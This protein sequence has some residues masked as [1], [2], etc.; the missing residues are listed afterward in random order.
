[1][2]V[3]SP[4]I[5]D[6]SGN[7]L[8][9]IDLVDVSLDLQLQPLS[10]AEIELKP[11]DTIP[12]RSWIAVYTEH[13]LAGIFRSRPQRDRYGERSSRVSLVHGAC[14]LND[15][16]TTKGGDQEQDP[17]NIAIAYIMQ[18][19]L[20]THWRLGT[21]SATSSVVYQLNGS[22]VLD[23][24][25][26]IMEQLPGYM[27]V[28]DQ[29]VTPWTLNVLPR[30][31]AVSAEG[32][33][34]R[35][36]SSVEISRDDTSLCNRVYYGEND[37]FVEDAAAIQRH[38]GVIEYR[39]NESGLT[40]VQ[41]AT[42]AQAYL[43]NH[44]ESKLSV[45]ISAIDFYNATGEP[46]D[47][48]ALGSKYRLAIPDAET[49]ENRV[50]EAIIC[51]IHY[52]SVFSN[53]PQITLASDPDTIITFLKKQRRSGGSARQ[54]A[55]EEADKQ[56]Q[57]WV[58]ENDVYK[59]SVYKIMGVMYDENGNVIYQTD[60]V[61]G[62]VIVDDA[63]N[64]VPVYNTE[65][66]GS[67]AGQVTESATSLETLYTKTGVRTLPSGET[68]IVSYTSKV[69]QT[70]DSIKSEVEA[71]RDGQ[72]SLKSRIDQEADKIGLFVELKNGQYVIKRAGIIAAINEDGT[73]TTTISADKIDLEGYVTADQ[74]FATDTTIGQYLTA[75]NAIFQTKVKTAALE[76]TNGATIESG[77]EVSD[78]STLTGGVTVDSLTVGY[79]ASSGYNVTKAVLGGMVKDITLN[80]TTN[81]LTITKFNGDI[82]NF[83]KAASPGNLT[84]SWS[85]A[86]YTVTNGSQNWTIDFDPTAASDA[87]WATEIG[88]GTVS[89]T[90]SKWLDFPLYIGSYNQGGQMAHNV[91]ISKS[92]NATAV[93]T[94]GQDSVVS[95]FDTPSSVPSTVTP[96][97][98]LK[99][100]VRRYHVT[101]DGTDVVDSY[102]R[103]PNYSATL[104]SAS[105]S[106]TKTTLSDGVY[107]LYVTKDGAAEQTPIAYYEVSGSG[108]GGG[109]RTARQ[110]LT[111][112]GEDTITLA[113][114]DTETSSHNL[115]A[116]YTS[117]T[118][119]TTLP[120]KIDAKEVYDAGVTAGLGGVVNVVKQPWVGN[121]CEFRPSAGNGSSA[122]VT[123]TAEATK[124]APAS[125]TETGEI[126]LKDGDNQITTK[127]LYLRPRTLDGQSYVVLTDSSSIVSMGNI[128][129]KYSASGGGSESSVYAIVQNGSITYSSDYQT[130]FVPVAAKDEN[131]TTLLSS[132]IAAD[133]TDAWEN[134]YTEGLTAGSG[135]EVQDTKDI[136]SNPITSNNSDI[137]IDPDGSA[138]AMGHVRLAVNVPQE[139]TDAAL[140]R[141]ND[142]VSTYNTW[143][144]Y[145]IDQ[146][147]TKYAQLRIAQANGTNAYVKI[148]ASE[149]YERGVAAG[150]DT[151]G[152]RLTTVELAGTPNYFRSINVPTGTT[153]VN[154]VTGSGALYQVDSSGSLYVTA[155]TI[156]RK[157][158]GYL[159]EWNDSTNQYEKV[160]DTGLG[161]WFYVSGNVTELLTKS[162]LKVS[163]A[164]TTQYTV[165]TGSRQAYVTDSSGTIVLYTKG[166]TVSDTYYIKTS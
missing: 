155:N 90:N 130:A 31:E 36:I 80:S 59:R 85:G 122:S 4:I 43:D 113:A 11:G 103:V 49:E 140:Y 160:R 88:T 34:S 6:S 148:D 147:T 98:L 61:T 145:T 109:T 32:R 57:H 64:P 108:S 14:E 48:I 151:A 111:P 70:A 50:I 74:I 131:G 28:F 67:I 163:L 104:T 81:V 39:I 136:R 76:A 165:A 138:L 42:I 129:A 119:T 9:R 87:T 91:T 144:G 89:Q 159:Y 149:V 25:T 7:V 137:R 100:T 141:S 106:G 24:I 22:G 99:G 79:P 16:L 5:L 41:L 69:K 77:L 30:P 82:I 56:Y 38:G 46:L 2:N 60:P 142:S 3:V 123:I 164:S 19:Y 101:K 139:I 71:A 94:A 44:K 66:D 73:S 45:S 95:T 53:N 146:L 135:M 162:N 47:R 134:G 102:F 23:A 153:T 125:A 35:N 118:D 120:I 52:D 152:Y 63:G 127:N 33:L 158:Y 51:S 154:A 15:Y 115:V 124:V 112:S 84:G 40:N 116:Y 166:S 126:V 62:E 133:I 110:L 55:K 121:T 114:T 37:L 117:G 1:M 65:S 21:V 92:I 97:D 105:T 78:G 143:S 20:G 10:S 68:S 27:L 96:T 150:A 17:A 128:L 107:G 156:Q 26:E 161:S 86:V 83:S 29:S 157:R 75:N 12:E 54:I 18:F 132:S 93:Y 72:T 58:T 8:R 13:G